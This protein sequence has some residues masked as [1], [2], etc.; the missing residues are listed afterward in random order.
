MDYIQRLLID[1]RVQEKIKETPVIDLDKLD[2]NQLAL[3]NMDCSDLCY[4]ATIEAAKLDDKIKDVERVLEK[5]RSS[6]MCLITNNPEFKNRESR[7]AEL[8]RILN[9]DPD[10]SASIEELRQLKM[11]FVDAGAQEAFWR[12]KER[13]LN[14]ILGHEFKMI[15]LGEMREMQKAKHEAEKK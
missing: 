12:R 8:A 3:W 10:F 5:V 11:C 4:L 2:L 1:K 9:E 7:E 6:R 13:P 15:E 14:I